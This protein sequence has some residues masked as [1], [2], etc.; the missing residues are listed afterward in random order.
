MKTIRI[1][2]QLPRDVIACL[3]RFHALVYEADDLERAELA[4]LLDTIWRQEYFGEAVE[5]EGY[6]SAFSL[7]AAEVARQIARSYN[8]PLKP[9]MFHE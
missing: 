2:R 3:A 1:R 9:G 8:L 5:I 4:R 6:E 7:G